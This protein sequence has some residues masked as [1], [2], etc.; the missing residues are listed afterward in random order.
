MCSR[1]VVF[2]RL[3][4]GRTSLRFSRVLPCNLFSLFQVEQVDLRTIDYT[5]PWLVMLVFLY[6]PRDVP[7]RYW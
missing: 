2:E 4:L 1:M 7:A 3:R 6:L 5:S